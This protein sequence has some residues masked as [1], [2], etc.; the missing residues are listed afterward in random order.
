MH[1]FRHTHIGVNTLEK[2]GDVSTNF[3]QAVPLCGE[4]TKG[5]SKENFSFLCWVVGMRVFTVSLILYS[6]HI[7][8]ESFCSNSLYKKRENERVVRAD[9]KPLGEET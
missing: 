1:L 2:Q 6:S 8:C 5:K 9:Y 4:G 3:Q 7:L